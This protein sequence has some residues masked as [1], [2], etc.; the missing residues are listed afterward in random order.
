[1][2][3]LDGVQF[4]CQIRRLRPLERAPPRHVVPEALH[5]HDPAVVVVGARLRRARRFARAGAATMSAGRYDRHDRRS[6]PAP[7]LR[8]RHP[9]HAVPPPPA[10]GRVH[11]VHDPVPDRALARVLFEAAPGR[12]GGA[13]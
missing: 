6:A 2:P 7:G 13:R 11:G 4:D 5:A 3:T 10:V 9:A 1:M 8:R 12:G